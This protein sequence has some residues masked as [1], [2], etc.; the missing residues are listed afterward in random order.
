MCRGCM[1]WGKNTR[2]GSGNRRAA[3]ANPARGEKASLMVSAPQDLMLFRQERRRVGPFRGRRLDRYG[4][5]GLFV[6]LHPLRRSSDQ[7]R[8]EALLHLT[9]KGVL[10]QTE[11]R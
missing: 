6:N 1:T 2:F 7:K 3:P 4:R 9:P 5:N 11:M 10:I 8:G